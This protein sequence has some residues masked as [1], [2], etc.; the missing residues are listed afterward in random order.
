VHEHDSAELA[1]QTDESP[2]LQQQHMHQIQSLGTTTT[3]GSRGSSSSSSSTQRRNVG[4]NRLSS[5]KGATSTA[6]Q[7][8]TTAVA[9]GDEAS[10][11]AQ[12]REDAMSLKIKG[13]PTVGGKIVDRN[14]FNS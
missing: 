1:M 3:I 9:P 13:I 7:A 12:E 4:M 10:L 11:D 14:F 8:A 5:R 6:E 2:T